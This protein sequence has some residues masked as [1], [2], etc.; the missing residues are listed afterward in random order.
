MLRILLSKFID[1]ILKTGRKYYQCVIHFEKTNI[2]KF[3]C[4]YMVL[5][6]LQLLNF[7][8]NDPLLN[9]PL[10]HLSTHFHVGLS[11]EKVKWHVQKKHNLWISNP[12][13]PESHHG[14]DNVHWLQDPFY[15]R[16]VL[17]SLKEISFSLGERPLLSLFYINSLYTW[18]FD[19]LESSNF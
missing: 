11:K 16:E 19:S 13:F 6:I 12:N 2:S 3:W 15:T 4:Y 8:I 1:N 9:F 18:T 5:A 10:L 17:Q 14:R 7:L